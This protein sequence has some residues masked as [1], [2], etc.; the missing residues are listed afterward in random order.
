MKVGNPCDSAANS[1][2]VH[3]VELNLCS[4]CI[5][6]YTTQHQVSR[7]LGRC[8][9]QCYLGMP[10]PEPEPGKFGG[11]GTD[12]VLPATS[13]FFFWLLFTTSVLHIEI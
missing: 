11:F 5:Y 4:V 7:A 3:E 2:E 12:F 1:W 9:S 13:I 6:L 8:L 10:E